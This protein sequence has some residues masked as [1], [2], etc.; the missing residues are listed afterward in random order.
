MIS[1]ASLRPLDVA[2]RVVADEAG[3]R[4]DACA[5]R[6]S[7]ASR[8]TRPR[9][10]RRAN[11]PSASPMTTIVV[12]G[13]G[14]LLR[15]ARA[16]ASNRPALAFRGA[17][18]RSAGRGRTSRRTPP[19]AVAADSAAAGAADGRP[20]RQNCACAGSRQRQASRRSPAAGHAMLGIM[21]HDHQLADRRFAACRRP[22]AGAAAP[23]TQP[24]IVRK[25][26]QL[27]DGP[28]VPEAVRPAAHGVTGCAAAPGSPPRQTRRAPARSAPGNGA[29]RCGSCR[30]SRPSGSPTSKPRCASMLLQLVA[31]GAREHALVARPGLHERPAAAQPVGEMADGERIGL[32][33]IVFHDRR[34]NSAAS[35]SRAPARPP[36]PA[37]RRG[38]RDAGTA[39][40][41]RGA[42]PARSHSRIVICASGR[43]AEIEALRQHDLVAPGLARA[44]SRPSSDCS[45]SRRSGRARNR[46]RRAGRRR[47]NR[48]RSA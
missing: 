1:R 6:R 36:A 22:L 14:L 42:M 25:K 9:A 23:P 18:R 16:R 8:R 27:E 21:P 40:R 28:A 29:A 26:C 19:N 11:R 47:R 5:R 34:G 32:G 17:G 44:P 2:A 24:P 39:C 4:C 43:R 35:G 13:V 10:R 3:S 12:V 20:S 38:R 33:R 41:R 37:D 46:R 31:L 7:R 30:P 15:A 45:R 48:P